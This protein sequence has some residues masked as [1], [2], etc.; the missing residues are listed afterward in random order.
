MQRYEISQ[1]FE[2]GSRQNW[3]SYQFLW[4]CF[5]GGSIST[6]VDKFLVLHSVLYFVFIPAYLSIKHHILRSL[7]TW[8]NC[9]YQTH[10]QNIIKFYPAIP[11][12]LLIQLTKLQIDI[13]NLNTTFWHCKKNSDYFWTRV[14]S[15]WV[16]G[17]RILSILEKNYQEIKRRNNNLHLEC[18]FPYHTC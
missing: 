15:V 5:L 4:R 2:I 7:L 11:K 9:R 18:P 3:F 16:M 12:Q 8:D 17:C 10:K 14:Y 1:Y 13:L 6:H